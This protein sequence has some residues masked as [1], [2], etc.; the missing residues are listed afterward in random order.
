MGQGGIQDLDRVE[1][2]IP[3]SRAP[4]ARISE[5]GGGGGGG[6]VW[7]LQIFEEVFSIKTFK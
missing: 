1:G 6:G 3:N 4:K 2:V 5:G 7:Q